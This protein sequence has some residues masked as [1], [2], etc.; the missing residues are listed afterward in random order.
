MGYVTLTLPLSVFFAIYRLGLDIVY[1]CATFDDSSF[2]HSRDMVGAHQ[3]LNSSHDLTML[4]S[5]MA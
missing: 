1:L 3:N 2:S 5:E 4:V